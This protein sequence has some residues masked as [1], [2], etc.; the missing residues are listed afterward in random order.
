MKLIAAAGHTARLT[1]RLILAGALL[2]ALAAGL[3]T[4]VLSVLR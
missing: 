1:W 3:V 2:T 4:T